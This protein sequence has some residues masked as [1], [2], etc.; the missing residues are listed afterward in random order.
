MTTDSPA[1]SR[2]PTNFLREII[3]D[4]LAQGVHQQVVTRFPPEP[5]GYL[6]IG[7]AKSICLNFGL[8]RDYGGK[9]HLRFDD[10]NPTR[11]NDEYVRS[12]QEDVR[13]LGFD[14]GENLFFASNYFEQLYGYAETL[15]RAGKAYVDSLT[16]D[17]VAAFRGSLT[18]AGRPSPYRERSVEENLDL[19]RRMRAGEFEEGQHV[20]RAKGDMSHPNMKMRDLPLYRIMKAHHHRTGDTWC[21]YPLYDFAHCLSD[22]IERITHSVC[23]LEFENNREVYDWILDNAGVPQPQP[24]QYEFARLALTYTVM[25]KRKLLELVEKKIVDGWDDPRMPTMAGLRRRGYTPESIRAFCDR[26]G[27]SKHNSLVDVELLEWAIRGDLEAR[28]LRLLGVMDPL[29]VVITNFPE[30]ETVTLDAPLRPEEGEAPPARRPLPFSRRLYIDRSDFAETPPSGWFRLAPGAEVRLR[31]AF[32]IV[33][34]SVVKDES[35]RVVRLECTYDPATRNQGADGRRVK[36]T[37]HWVSADHSVPVEARLY[38]RLFKDE[39]PGSGGRDPLESLNPSSLEIAAAA[40]IEPYA[41]TLPAGTRFQ[42]ERVGYFILDPKDSA[43]GRLVMN[44]TVTLKDGWA[45]TQEAIDPEAVRA[46]RDRQRAEEKVRSAQRGAEAPLSDAAAALVSGHGLGPAEA[47]FVTGSSALLGLFEAS[48]AAGASPTTAAT[49]MAASVQTVGGRDALEALPA[50]SFAAVAT[51]LTKGE[52]NA[53]G[54]KAAL[55]AVAAGKNAAEAV[56]ENRPVSDTGALEGAI[57][58]V[59]EK[60]ADAVSRYRAGNKNLIGF[61]VGQTVKALGGKADPAETR[62]QLERALDA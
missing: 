16:R 37:L 12:I 40:R 36:G 3:D 58:S 51:A 8:A 28:E 26:I 15:I 45:K 42:L 56:A 22:S 61:F 27:I 52:L 10:T 35:G 2:A 46:E 33:C 57:A 17:E 18:E 6:H 25:S 32:N 50:A 5:N 44:R 41:A 34:N 24:R 31:W 21:I 29:E 14:W 47:R 54:A 39:E 59:L 4:H 48:L 7:H 13:W 53:S 30:G 19:F 62:R 43:P 20:L 60:N 1:P 9:C 38:D 23:T 55:A 49:F 11:E